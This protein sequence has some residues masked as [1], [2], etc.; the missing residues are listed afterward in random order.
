M[1][2]TSAKTDS[3]EEHS[4]PRVPYFFLAV[5][6][7]GW[8]AVLRVGWAGVHPFA[9]DE[10]RLSLLALELARAGQVPLLGMVSSAGVPN[11][12]GAV[13]LFAI[14]FTLSS[15]P[16]VAA[17]FIGLVG[18]ITVVLAWGLARQL[19]GEAGGLVT[20]WLMAGSPYLAF[21][22]RSI[23]AQ[24]W[25]PFLA[26]LWAWAAWYGWKRGRAWGFVAQGFVAAFAPQVHYAGVTLVG[27]ALMA[28]LLATNRRRA[29]A[30]TL[31]GMG[32]AGLLA[33]PSLVALLPHM[34]AL[35]SSRARAFSALVDMGQLVTGY[36]WARLLVG[37]GTTLASDGGALAM[38]A[39]LLV[40]AAA[41]GV[42]VLSG[43]LDGRGRHRRAYGLVLLW[44]LSAPLLWVV[45]PVP[46]RVHYQLASLPAWFLI[47]GGSV[48]LVR[49]PAVQRALLGMTVGISLVQGVQF[50]RGLDLVGTQF[51]PGGISTPLGYARR[52]AHFVADG[53]P[54]IVVVPGTDPA[55]DG[56]AAMFEVLLW[57][58]P[59]RL[60]DGR[61]A[62]IVPTR[63]SWLLFSSSW[64]PALDE[65]RSRLPSTAWREVRLPKRAGEWPFVAVHVTPAPPAGFEPLE[66][67]QFGNLARLEGIRRE[68]S[69]RGLRLVTLWRVIGPPPAERVHQFNHIYVPTQEQ[70]VQ[71]A[72]IPVS[73]AA[74]RP[75]D[76]VVTWTEF[77]APLPQEGAWIS[78]GLYLYPSLQR[79]PAQ[80]SIR[81]PLSM[82]PEHPHNASP[83]K[84]KR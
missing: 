29:L 71:V 44:A 63:P 79:L 78:T 76:W 11:L 1:R 8:A 70:P 66:S 9:Y 67:V 81:L 27:P 83:V 52:A 33:L 25:L 31:L 39:G 30:L 60:V 34:G 17:L 62:L 45:L 10:A 59:H 48:H 51:T 22:S 23:W 56:D 35:P 64:L 26:V 72:D 69:E 49:R 12:P 75:G 16:L 32:A 14:P 18:T 47:L 13:W 55:V 24:N 37:P 36:G 20:A 50:A 42:V 77:A 6:S 54:V 58:V 65:L 41:G 84:G 80:A 57:D 74:W 68:Y 15:D 43:V 82:S 28:A 5:A 3:R 7:V 4:R 53:S 40:L 38:A 73:S 21:Y 61:N 2:G 19:W 46:A